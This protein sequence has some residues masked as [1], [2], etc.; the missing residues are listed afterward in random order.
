MPVDLDTP[1]QF[2]KGVGPRRARMLESAGI[3]TAED[4]LKYGPFRYE[5]RSNFRRIRDLSSEEEVVIRGVITVSGNYATPRRG[6][7]IFEMSVRDETG[8]V[9]AKFFNQPYLSRVFK[10]GKE[11]VLFGTPRYDSYTGALAFLNPETELV[12]SE[13]DSAVHTGRIVPVYRKIGQISARQLRQILWNLVTALPDALKETLPSELV[14]R[15]KFPSLRDAITMLHFPE[16]PGGGDRN[17]FLE[18]LSRSATPAQRRFI[19]EEFFLFQLGLL[20]V[21]K[22]V[23]SA[24]KNHSIRITDRARE[25]IKSILPFHPT[26]AQKKVLKE[27][28]SDMVS[29]RVMSRLLQGD[30]GSGKTIVALQAIVLAIESGYQTALMAPTELLAEQHF[31]NI[32]RYLEGTPYRVAFLSGSVKGKARKAV[33][34][35]VEEGN[36]D[37]LIGTHALIQGK[38]KFRSLAFVVIDEQH[39][40]GVI[41]RSKL[42]E[43]GDLPDTLVMT[44]TPIPRSLALT[45]YGDLSVSI[46]D[47]LP[48]GR[49]PVKTVVKNENSR[50]EV[51]GSILQQLKEGRQVYIVYPLVEES[52]KLDLKA[53]VEMADQLQSTLFVN[54]NVGLLHGRMKPDEKDELMKRFLSGDLHV[55]VSTTVIEVGIDVPNATVM[56]IEHAERFGLSQLHQLRGRIGRGGHAGLCVLMV[57]KVR[58]KEAYGRLDIMRKTSDGF[59]IAEKDLEIRGPG[60][61][62]G[63]K[64]SGV[65]QFIFGNIVRDRKLLEL[66]RQE[67]ERHL[68]RVGENREHLAAL[69][70]IIDRWRTKYG[71]YQVG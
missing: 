47:E 46:L 13:G 35:E 48:P 18:D 40:F 60:D 37:L 5:D 28:V 70:G 34:V 69:F 27:I 56:V 64:Q 22:K 42:M 38:V 44:A 31:R 12:G 26:A 57:D 32:K 8:S 3:R 62:I 10:E 16:V 67:A 66:A 20:L 17:Q 2:I 14:K 68:A 15:W 36:T 53:A 11:I 61:F 1:V 52:E 29:P 49:Q 9:S 23:E 30:V 43:K 21:R 4:L 50:S 63:T 51:Y 7:K 45:V 55:L 65:P 39:R 33:L 58:T 25:R 6:M 41:Q 19:F 54:Y 59:R 24:P 71:L